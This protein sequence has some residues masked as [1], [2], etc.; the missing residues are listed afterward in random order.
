[1]ND[2]VIEEGDVPRSGFNRRGTFKR[3]L[4]VERGIRRGRAFHPALSVRAGI[5]P[6]AAHFLG[7]FADMDHT[8]NHGVLPGWQIA[9]VLV[10][11]EGCRRRCHPL[12]EERGMVEHDVGTDELF[13]NVEEPIVKQGRHPQ[14]RILLHIARIDD[15]FIVRGAA[16]VVSLS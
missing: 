13:D 6:E 12:L 4:L 5:D 11:V 9:P 14:P 7:G 8:C 1:M 10:H 15:T 3:E 2:E 16:V